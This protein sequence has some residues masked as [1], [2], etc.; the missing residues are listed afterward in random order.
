[1]FAFLLLGEKGLEIVYN[2]VRYVS[3]KE[4]AHRERPVG[5]RAESDEGVT[6]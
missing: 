5:W 4:S 6:N 2:L 3:N 1:L